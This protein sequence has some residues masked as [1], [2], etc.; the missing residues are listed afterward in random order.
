MSRKIDVIRHEP[1][2]IEVELRLDTRTMHFEAEYLGE[3]F[4]DKD[5]QQVKTAVLAAIAAKHKLDFKPVIRI[6]VDDECAFERRAKVG[7]ALSRSYLAVDKAGRVHE[8]EW[9]KIA[10]APQKPRQCNA[11]RAKDLEHLPACSPLESRGRKHGSY[12]SDGVILLAY[13]DELWETLLA[14]VAG[15]HELRYDLFDALAAKVCRAK[16]WLAA[17]EARGGGDG[18]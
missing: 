14:V 15:L 11:I 6:A 9:N 2:G 7:I 18:E 8:I 17:F 4:V 3:H 16:H 1:T 13:T 10:E 12:Y 5:G